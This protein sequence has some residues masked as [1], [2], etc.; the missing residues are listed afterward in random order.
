[1]NT[2]LTVHDT[3]EK[4]SK[5]TRNDARKKLVNNNSSNNRVIFSTKFNRRWPNV[6]K[7]IK[8][9]L[10]LLH[11]N[12]ILK[13]LFPG[14]SILGANKRENN[15]KGLLLRSDPYNIKKDLLD[16]TKH[17]Y[18]SCK[19]KCDSCNNFV[20]EVAAIKCFTAGRIFK[21]RRDNS[22]QTENVIYLAYCLDCQKQGVDSTVS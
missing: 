2:H 9:S 15:L 5:I 17:G 1:M 18:K 22:C 19:E 4:I 14:N 8:D 13:G 12:E 21:I 16:N 20:D 10:H 11:N 6:T 7:I 3:F